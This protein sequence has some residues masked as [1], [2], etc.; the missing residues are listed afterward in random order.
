MGDLPA[1][2]VRGV[3][4]A[5]LAV[6]ALGTTAATAYFYLNRP[7]PDESDYPLPVWAGE[8]PFRLVAGPP[9][10]DPRQRPRAPLPACLGYLPKS[11]SSS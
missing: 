7:A 6:V 11:E 4:L 2:R 10:P 9:V 5:S 8:I 1:R 3:W